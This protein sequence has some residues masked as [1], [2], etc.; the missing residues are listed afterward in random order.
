MSKLTFLVIH[1]T[2]TPECREV[3]KDDIMSWHTDP[4]PK[5]R[6][7]K[8]AGYT[9]IIH[10]DGSITNITP[11]DQDDDVDGFEITNGVRGI[12]SISRHVV[13]VGGCDE[14]M[15]PKDTRTHEQMV[16][17][18][19]YIKYQVLRHPEIKVAGHNQFSSKA[20]PSFDV[21]KFCQVIGIDCKNIYQP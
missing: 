11:Y 21:P 13:Y 2:A 19:T 16:A 1:C 18:T 9:D 15:Q 4:K 5:G 12:N 3:S 6:G 10:L 14:K 20:C 8:K 7:W 17:L